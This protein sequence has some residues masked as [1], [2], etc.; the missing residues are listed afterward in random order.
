VITAKLLYNG[1]QVGT[2]QTIN[3]AGIVGNRLA[4]GS[5]R[6]ARFSRRCGSGSMIAIFL[7]PI[8]DANLVIPPLQEPR[9]RTAIAIHRR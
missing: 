2:D 7:A 8:E 4:S 9:G 3:D 5:R 1:T 6:M